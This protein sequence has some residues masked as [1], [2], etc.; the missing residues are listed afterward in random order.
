MGFYM[1]LA[2]KE[3]TRKEFYTE[4]A[5]RTEDTEKRK[6]KARDRFEM[7][8]NMLRPYD[9]MPTMEADMRLAMVPA[10][11]ARMPNL[12]SWPRC[13]GARAPMPPI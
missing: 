13:S 4:N 11:M 9:R 5:G 2:E 6:H 3:K 8:R 10:S 1:E 7:P 12:A